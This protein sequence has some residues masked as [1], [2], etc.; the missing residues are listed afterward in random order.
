MFS[1]QSAFEEN[2]IWIIC[3]DTCFKQKAKQKA[4]KIKTSLILETATGGV[5]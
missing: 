3:K 1:L 4:L 5:L 2:E